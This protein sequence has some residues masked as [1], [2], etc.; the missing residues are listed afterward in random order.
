MKRAF[1]YFFGLIFLVVFL[2]FP[3]NSQGQELE[4]AKDD[5]LDLLKATQQVLIDKWLDLTTSGSFDEPEEQ[6][7]LFLIRNAIQK[8]Q[9]SYFVKELPKEYLKAL[10]KTAGSL[11]FAEKA[12][13]FILGEIEKKSVK[14]AVGLTTD[15]LLA[16]EIRIGQGKLSYPFESYKGNW[17]EPPLHYLIVYQEVGADPVRGLGVEEK[18]QNAQTSNGAGTWAEVAIEFYSPELMEPPEPTGA[19]ILG[20]RR[21]PWEF[22]EWRAAGNE[23]LLPFIVRIKG[24]V[25]KDEAIGYQWQENRVEISFSE[26][27]PYFPEEK[28]TWISKIPFLGSFYRNF[29]Q[30]LVE[31][32][33]IME[34]LGRLG[35]WGTGSV[36]VPEMEPGE[37]DLA[38]LDMEKVKEVPEEETAPT[39]LLGPEAEGTGG[40]LPREEILA[41]IQEELDDIAEGI[42]IINQEVR[43]LTAEE[44]VGDVSLD[45]VSPDGSSVS[46]SEELEE[47]VEQP[48]EE[49]GPAFAPDESAEA[50]AE[51]EGATAGKQEFCQKIPGAQ[52]IR[53][54]VIL[55]EIAWMGTEESYSNEWIELK[56]ISGETVD[57]TGWQLFNKEQKIKIIFSRDNFLTGGFWLL[58]RTDDETVPGKAADLIYTG[59]LK[60]REEVLYLFDS[61]CH[62]QD[63]V[64]A[65]PDWPAG[66]NS[67]KRTM[68]RR[69]DLT[70]Q[71]SAE[72]GGTPKAENSSGYV[73]GGGGGGAPP[74]AE[75]EPP[76][77]EPEEEPEEP[78]PVPEILITEVQ[79]RDA[80]SSDHDFI[81][82]YNL[83]TTTVDISGL[84]LKKKS[85]TGEECSV[86]VFPSGSQILSQSYFLW[87]NSAYVSSSQISA[88][89]VNTTSSQT[90]AKNNS[91]A[92]LNQD[93]SI[94]DAVAWGSST[95]PFL[96]GLPF[97]QNPEHTQTLGRKWST[98]TQTY[99]D[100]DNNAE[101]FELQEPTPGA[102]NKPKTEGGGSGGEEEGEDEEPE[103]PEPPPENQ[104][105]T[106]LFTFS[107]QNPFVGQETFFNAASS[108]DPDGQITAYFWDF[109]D[110][111]TTTTSQATT[112]HS[113]ASSTPYLISLK[114]I[115]DDGA[116]STP[117]T[118]TITVSGDSGGEEEGEDEEP[119]P[120]EPPPE[121]PT[122]SVVINEIAW[123]G[124]KAN[125][126]DEWLELYNNASTEID[127]N[128][129]TLTWSH[130]TTTHSLTFS[131]ST[132]ALTTT[133]PAAGFYLLERTDDTTI[134]DI[135]ADLIYTGGLHND[136]E[137]LE[138]R[139]TQGNLIDQVD[140]SNAWF[141]GENKKEGN[142]WLRISMER[143]NST[144]T[145]ATSTNWA[146]NNRITKN[147]R[148]ASND[149]LNATPKAENSVSK[150]QTEIS[151]QATYP[152][153]TYL[154]S[155]Y[156]VTGTL[157]VPQDK[158]LT[159]E[160][161]VTLK[162]DASVRMIVQGKLEAIGK[163]E[164]ENKIVFVAN[165]DSPWPNYWQGIYFLNSAG[166]KLENVIVRY[167][168]KIYIPFYELPNFWAGLQ[169]E[170]SEISIQN[171]LIENCL[172]GGLWLNNSTSTVE[173]VE[174][175]NIKDQDSPYFHNT[176]ALWIQGG[177]ALIKNSIFRENTIGLKIKGGACPQIEN[178]IFEGNETPIYLQ[179]VSYPIFS[180]NQAHNN[181]LN[182]IFADASTI[183][184]DI[185]WSADLPY[186]IKDKSIEAGATLT[187]KAG[188]QLQ[189][190]NGGHLTIDGNL[191]TEG[192]STK[193]VLITSLSDSPS[194]HWQ[195]LAF[196]SS[197]SVLD[198]AIIRYGGG[199]CDAG[200]CWGAITQS[201]DVEIEI[202]NSIIENNTWGIFSNEAKCEKVFEKIKI[203]NTIFRENKFNIR[204]PYGECFP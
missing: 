116:F 42:D 191:I 181:D 99:I 1:L 86:R 145:G 105:P 75:P 40:P 63:K 71:T 198:G 103:P 200:Y 39:V 186:I 118:T 54:K 84:Q 44:D 189:L 93:K 168:G 23:V 143:I 124:T 125:P 80:F 87:A 64:G 79:I 34:K 88:D 127:L 50:L 170:N 3:Q 166:S 97:S 111:A 57:L 119:E 29:K 82:L 13:T 155:P 109:G 30:R 156:I 58:E 47:F 67:S 33:K 21:V 25:L 165:S 110:N 51:E 92:L 4:L 18:A 76:E 201:K 167:G 164:E 53:N 123:M 89:L 176:A 83:A 147:G 199:G 138:L 108:T 139:D 6:A 95:D 203:E 98:S 96:E 172:P 129:W 115:D 65:L 106:A 41:R 144:F 142:K 56:N 19:S 28:D 192:T 133:I 195:R 121:T 104:A 85:S 70:W 137:K 161:G 20:I 146:S 12:I 31:L 130:G 140:C 184:S 43:E 46:I 152:I 131:T 120:P 8:R 196:Y 150:S 14:E 113:F 26:P 11:L 193:P 16:N 117:A 69:T 48:L 72:I 160:P 66:D 60:N 114:V 132:G 24:R 136:G 174:F 175:S 177:K 68:E 100:T 169:V 204:R 190:K 202:K 149:P 154:G 197:G 27:V 62:L 157:T 10:L 7:A 162:F 178:N 102:E 180:S 35:R 45:S 59:A 134:S 94:I 107:P 9:F 194:A 188:T 135:S 15:W 159:I 52:A 2:F 141:A 74:P 173:N 5:T 73:A 148:D 37:Q 55:N 128:N 61:A 78:Q 185:V 22:A 38:V 158:T 101:D 81:E 77:E 171:S 17:Q 122:L 183:I 187:L 126:A 49:V 91:L 153:L 90:L 179:G 32:K 151:G 112:T 182:G 36:V 163:E